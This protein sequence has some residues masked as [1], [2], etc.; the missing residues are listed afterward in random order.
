MA[1]NNDIPT[2]IGFQF[3][4]ELPLN[5]RR[6]PAHKDSENYNYLPSAEPSRINSSVKS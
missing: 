6:V 3:E 5:E 4:P 1:Y 2:V